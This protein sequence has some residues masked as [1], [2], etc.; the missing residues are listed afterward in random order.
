M[1]IVHKAIAKDPADRYQTPGALAEDLRRFLED[2]PI[3]ARQTGAIE[4]AWRWCRRNPGI[5][6]SAGSAAVALMTAALLAL[7]YANSQA[8]ATAKITGLAHQISHSL[9]ES[10]HRLAVLDLERGQTACE[11]GEID[12]GLL[13]MVESLRAA[14][15]VNDSALRHAARANLS[16]WSRYLPKLTGAF[17]HGGLV[18]QVAFSPDGATIVT[19][20]SDG[21]AQFRDVATG[22]LDRHQPLSSRG[23]PDLDLQPGRQ[24]DPDPKPG[25]RR[26]ALG[27]RH[28]PT[29]RPVIDAAR[30]R[31][32]R[33]LQPRRQDDP[34]RE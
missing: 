6:V 33:G 1:T 12:R 9:N 28:R 19:G 20:C 29:R 17:S 32:G 8:K 25:R 27:G 18:T 5:A 21:K 14:T 13:L 7:F 10:N 23:R 15:A 2:R 22:Q 24:V 3:V 26:S 30:I 34:D 4:R 11:R 16:A 31:R